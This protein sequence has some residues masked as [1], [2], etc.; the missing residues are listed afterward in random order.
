MGY[1]YFWFKLDKSHDF[2]GNALTNKLVPPIAR[3][4]GKYVSIT[5][6]ENMI[7]NNKTEFVED[8]E[9]TLMDLSRYEGVACKVKYLKLGSDLKVG[10]PEEKLKKLKEQYAQGVRELKE[11]DSI[12]I[13]KSFKRPTLICKKCGQR[14]NIQSMT[15]NFCPY[16]GFDTRSETNMAKINEKRQSVLEIQKRLEKLDREVRDKLAV[17]YWYVAVKV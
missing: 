11:M 17:P 5:W 14:I 7:Y 2:I 10:S 16:C 3:Q 9:E 1:Q 6:D 15:S 4:R 13:A 12:I 8:M